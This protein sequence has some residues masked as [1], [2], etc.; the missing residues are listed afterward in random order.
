M[1]G[2]WSSAFRTPDWRRREP[3]HVAPVAASAITARVGHLMEVMHV[4]VDRRAWLVR[5]SFYLID[6]TRL[7][8][9]RSVS[10]L[11]RNWHD[12]DDE[13]A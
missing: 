2:C 4:V 5:A 10:D 9:P 12:Q 6:A 8:L 13:G 11:A 3:I 7:A 1:D